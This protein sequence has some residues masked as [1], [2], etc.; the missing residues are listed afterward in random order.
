MEIRCCACGDKKER[1]LTDGSE[2]YPHRKDLHK[3][4]FWKC[5]ECGNYVGCHHQTKDRTRPLGNIPTPELRNARKHIH[6]ILDPIWKN[7]AMS[8]KEIYKR[9]SD[10]LGWKY[11]TAMIRSID[12]AKTV[13]KIVLGIKKGGNNGIR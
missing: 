12:E 8:R 7:G 10:V 3:L 5:D 6:A 2:I 1:R 11:H 9:I 4:P 13:Y